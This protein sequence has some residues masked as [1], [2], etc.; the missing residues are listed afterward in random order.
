MTET[1]TSIS[2]VLSGTATAAQQQAGLRALAGAINGANASGPSSQIMKGV[3]VS[4]NLTGSPPTIN[5]NMNGDSST[6]VSG[7]IFLDSYT[8]FVGDVVVCIEQGN[9]IFAVGQAANGGTSAA[10]GWISS[11]TN[12]AI[13]LGSGTTSGAN[14]GGPIEARLR[15]ESGSLKVEM[16]GTAG[17][18]GSGVIFTLPAG[19]H[20]SVRRPLSAA[21]SGSS[22]SGAV[23]VQ[24]SVETN[25]TIIPYVNGN[26]GTSSGTT[27]SSGVSGGISTDSQSESVSDSGS[28]GG[29]SAGTAH[30]HGYSG[31]GSTS[32][33]SHGGSYSGGSHTHSTPSH[34][35]SISPVNPSW[36][37]FDGLEF[38]L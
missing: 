37:S 16:Q 27:G 1:T 25:G 15:M 12:P 26:T 34:S 21:C 32:G 14:G 3:V 28:T 29:A 31:G 20:P 30:T 36:I 7:I 18:T 19:Y 17:W 23:I 5:C 6:L 22:G 33:H 2:N 11:S 24:V 38:Y 8:P 9:T 35:H 4:V 10:N 13:T